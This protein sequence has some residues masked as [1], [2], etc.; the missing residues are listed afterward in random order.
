MKWETELFS[1]KKK[2]G[3]YVHLIIRAYQEFKKKLVEIPAA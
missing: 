2:K 3:T 1:V